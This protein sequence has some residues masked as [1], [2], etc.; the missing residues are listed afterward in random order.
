MTKITDKIFNN[1]LNC[2]HRAFISLNENKLSNYENTKNQLKKIHRH[3]AIKRLKAKYNESDILYDASLSAINGNKKLLIDIKLTR[4]EFS[5]HTD[6]LEKSSNKSQRNYYIPILFVHSEKLQKEDKMLLGYHGLVIGDMQGR[7]P[8]YG[9]I[10]YGEQCNSS[11]IT[12]KTQISSARKLLQNFKGYING[13]TPSLRLNKHCNICP[14]QE[15]CRSKALEKDDLSLLYGIN[16]KEIMKQHNKGIFTVTQLSYTFRPRRRKTENKHL[17]E[18]K[19]LALREQKIHLYEKPQIPSSKTQ[20]FLDIEGDPSR[21]FD[22]LIGLIILENSKI[23]TFSFWADTPRQQNK[24]YRDFL[25]IIKNYKEHT[26]YHYGSYEIKSIQKMK[27]VLG[28]KNAESIIKNSVNMLSIIYANV[29][30]PTFSN[31]LKDIAKYLSY[32]WHDENASGI[33]SLVWRYQFELSREEKFKQKLIEYNLDDCFALKRVTE[34]LQGFSSSDSDDIIFVEKMK[35]K[36]TYKWGKVDFLLPEFEQINNCAYF[37]YQREKVLVRTN[38]TIK[39]IT[40]REMCKRKSY[41]INKTFLF[42][43][44]EDCHI[45]GEK[46]YRHGNYSKINYNLKFSQSGIKRWITKF[47]AKRTRCS[48]CKVVVMS[49]DYKKITKYGHGLISWIMYQ[50]IAGHLPFYRIQKALEDQFSLSTGSNPQK[51]KATAAN[52]YKETYKNI[53]CKIVQGELIHIDETQVTIQKQKGYVWAFTNHEEVYFLYTRSREGEFLKEL[54]H[55][56]KGVLISDFYE[57]YSQPE[58]IQQKC[59]I[60]LIRDLNDD[61]REHPF[62]KEYK[63][64]VSSFGFLL[65]NIIETIDLYGLRRRYLKKHNKDVKR[66]FKKIFKSNFHSEIAQKYQKRFKKNEKKLFTFLNYDNVSWNNNNAEHAIK[67]FAVY[68]NT[69][70]AKVNESGLRDYLILLS[71]YQTCKFK[72]INFLRFMISREKNIDNYQI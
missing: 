9:K 58:W 44:I 45:C 24:I 30:F 62:D 7:M 55:D 1:L 63:S 68:R 40:H 53:L 37:D 28:K 29:Y 17:F 47:S 11:R 72:G 16:E 6:A 66:Y 59:L 27:D 15:S 38:K 50:H 5:S 23:K 57:V 69:M 31:S 65:K 64:I 71:I 60:H 2:E 14:F 19:A 34:F 46:M 42:P 32:R 4:N 41:K 18:L 35:K 20:I 49:N 8:E 3:H 48:E 22:Y 52:F 39:K 67:H 33:Q 36:S 13:K 21:K 54:L 43:I 10:I 56:F 61:L 12:L 26:I 51:F 25:S 70:S